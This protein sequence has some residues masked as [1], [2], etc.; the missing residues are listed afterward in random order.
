[1]FQHVYSPTREHL[2]QTPSI[3]DLV[4][5]DEDYS[6]S[7][8]NYSDPLGRSD[9]CM[10]KFDYLCYTVNDELQF[11]KYLYAFGNHTDLV[12]GLLDIDWAQVLNHHLLSTDDMW[13]YFITSLLI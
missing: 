9:H 12:P 1:M 6:L 8:L 5:T 7:K 3:L 10:L 11:T 13:S 2:G 4:L